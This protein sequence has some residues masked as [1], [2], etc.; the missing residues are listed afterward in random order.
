M[1]RKLDP[2]RE[3]Q[4]HIDTSITLRGDYLVDLRGNQIVDFVGRYESLQTDFDHRCERIGLA[5]QQLPHRRRANDRIAYRDCYDEETKAPVTQ[6]FG[7]D[8][9]AFGYEF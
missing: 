9:E 6:H 2:Q 7:A 4:Y 1:R 5:M 3:W 8:M